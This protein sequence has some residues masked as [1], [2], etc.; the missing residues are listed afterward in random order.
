MTKEEK[1]EILE[2]LLQSQLDEAGVKTEKEFW[3]KQARE[4][5]CCKIIT[6]LQSC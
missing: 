2:K 1:R 3:E 4:C 6:K 5:S